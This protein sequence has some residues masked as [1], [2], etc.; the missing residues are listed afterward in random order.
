MAFLICVSGSAFLVSAHG[1]SGGNDIRTGYRSIEIRK[2]DTLWEIA[3][4]T[5]P[6]D[7]VSTP[8]YV[9]VL[10]EMNHLSSDT[11]M[12]GQHLIIMSDSI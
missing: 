3:E 9:Q 8:E 1:I 6:A 7:S 5:K 10:K 12:T 4:R 2:G 11:I